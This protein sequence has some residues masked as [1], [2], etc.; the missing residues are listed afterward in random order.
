MERGNVYLDNPRNPHRVA[1]A[2]A[3]TCR[4]CFPAARRR[5][6]AETFARAVPRAAE[7]LDRLRGNGTVESAFDWDDVGSWT[8][9]AKY[10]PE[11]SSTNVA[12]SDITT[13]DAHGNL[14]F[15]STKRRVALL[16]VND[17]IVIDTPDAVLVCHRH[18]AEKIKH[19]VAKVPPEL[20]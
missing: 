12:N 13:V 19:L 2:C 10:L 4:F 1:S 11:R 20:Q 17:L 7:D 15:T 5:R 18:E 9:I 8:A 6:R 16:G 14:V 3:G